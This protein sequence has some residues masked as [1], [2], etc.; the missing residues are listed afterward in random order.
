LV[1]QNESEPAEE[2]YKFQINRNDKWELNQIS[3]PKKFGKRNLTKD[4]IDLCFK[5]LM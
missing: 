5:E 2:H 4:I 1:F 3:T